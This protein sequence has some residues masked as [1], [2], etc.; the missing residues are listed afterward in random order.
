[1]TKVYLGRFYIANGRT[2]R[3]EEIFRTLP[4]AEYCRE[5]QFKLMGIGEE[6]VEVKEPT[7]DEAV[8]ALFSRMRAAYAADPPKE[9][10]AESNRRL[11]ILDSIYADKDYDGHYWE[12]AAVCTADMAEC[13]A[14]C[15]DFTRAL[16]CLEKVAECAAESPAVPLSDSFSLQA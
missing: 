15:G 16:V 13:Y 1:L 14:E 7:V 3:A 11:Q 9:R 5:N 12:H 2:A 4:E 8:L 6:E 10:L